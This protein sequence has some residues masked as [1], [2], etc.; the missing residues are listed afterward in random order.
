MDG[1]WMLYGCCMDVVWM[2][3]DV[4]W[5]LY[6]EH[7]KTAAKTYT[8]KTITPLSQARPDRAQSNINPPIGPKIDP[9]L[10]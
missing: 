8:Q 7:F 1:V 6:V 10:R 4:V 2:L 3:Y 9:S 5:M